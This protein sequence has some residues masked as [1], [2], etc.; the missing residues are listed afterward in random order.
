MK[1][2]QVS[3]ALRPLSETFSDV[4]SSLLA[5]IGFESFVPAEKGIEAYIPSALFSERRIDE[6]IAHYPL[7]VKITYSFIEMED[8]NWNEEWEKHYFQPIVIDDKCII[9]SSFHHPLGEYEYRIFIDPKMAFGTGHHQTT[10]LILGDILAMDLKNK[11]VLDMGAG[12][13]V[14]AILASMRGANPVLAVDI[15]EWAYENARENIELNQIT[16][17]RTLLGGA[18]VL[19]DES[20]DVIF[21]NINRNILLRDIPAYEKVLNSGGTLIMSGFYEEDIPFIRE[22]CTQC[23]LQYAGFTEQDRWVSVTCRK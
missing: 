22:K 19:G 3:F 12:T 13:A 20:F 15:D 23:G 4:L 2:N 9:Q 14:L 5:D 17:I 7:D 6:V 18:E 11:S 1:Y 21:A 8:K 10:G 16:N